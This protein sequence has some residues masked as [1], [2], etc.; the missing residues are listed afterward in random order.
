MLGAIIGD[1]IGSVY[2]MDNIKTKDFPLFSEKCVFTDDTV[3]T[4]AV[5]DAILEHKESG[6]DFKG[7]VLR[8]LKEYGRKYSSAGFSNRT[9]A[10]LLSDDMTPYNSWSNGAAMRVSPCAYLFD[11]IEDVKKYARMSAEVSHNHPD[12][13]KGAEAAAI[14]TFM[15]RKKRPKD[16]IRAVVEKDYYKIPDSLDELRKVYKFDLTCEGSIAPAVLAFLEAEDFEDTIRNAISIGGD[17]DTIAAIA[18]AM[19][20]GYYGIPNE[21][22]DKAMTYL[23]EDLRE[24]AVKNMK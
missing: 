7:I 24:I 15:A 16:E 22:I 2:E 1:I 9:R 17:S 14:A 18:G 13:V 6:A 11:D 8:K 10:W 5:A 19:A 23:D 4:V 21:I 20:E 12:G 3:Q